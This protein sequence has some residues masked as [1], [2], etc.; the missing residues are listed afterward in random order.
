M[1]VSKAGEI[2]VYTHVR[3]IFYIQTMHF[4]VIDGECKYMENYTKLF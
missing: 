3:K 4:V 1:I 2:R